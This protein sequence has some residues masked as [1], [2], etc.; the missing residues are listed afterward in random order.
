MSMKTPPQVFACQIAE[1]P[2]GST[3]K[4]GRADLPAQIPGP[5]DQTQESKTEELKGV[6]TV[7]YDHISLP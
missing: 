1:E 7:T 2:E 6:T 3:P 5:A 4:L